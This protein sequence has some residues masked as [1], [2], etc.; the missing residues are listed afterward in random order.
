LRGS[1]STAVGHKFDP[2]ASR[3][4][5]GLA[6]SHADKIRYGGVEL[7]LGCGLPVQR[8]AGLVLA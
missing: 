1:D 6:Q 4:S 2:C 3:C 8:R 5:D 7:A